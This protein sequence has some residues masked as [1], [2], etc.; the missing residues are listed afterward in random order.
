M[1]VCKRDFDETKCMYFLIK[2]ENVFGKYKEIWG[3][4]SNVIKIE[5]NSELV[6]NKKH[7]K[8]KNTTQK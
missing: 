7:L 8:A 3:K 1:S 4:N 5:F 2:D 6:Y